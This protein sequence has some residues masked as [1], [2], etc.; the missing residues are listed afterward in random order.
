M[1]AT[2]TYPTNA[3]VSA[4]DRRIQLWTS[5]RQRAQELKQLHEPDWLRYWDWYRNVQQ[6]LTDDADW[7]RSNESVP[8]VFKI[9]ETLLP[10]YILGMFDS[11][12]WFS[13]EAKNQ[14]S[15]LYEN[16]CENLIKQAVEEM[17]IFPKLVEA[18]RYTA[19]MGHCWGKVIWREDYETLQKIVPKELTNRE[20][21]DAR[22]G[23]DAVQA[24]SE[25]YGEEMLE[26]PSGEQGV[27]LEL[28][29]EKTF[30]G[31][32]F[33]WKTLDRIFPDP[34][35]RERWYIEEIHTTLEELEEVQDDVGVYNE[36]AIQA[37]REDQTNRQPQGQYGG[38]DHIG[39][40]R[41]GTSAGVSIEYAREPETTEGIP[42]WIVTPQREGIGVTLWQCWGW[43]PPDDRGPD[44][45]EWRITVIGEGKHILR[46]EPSP[47]PD[48]KPPYFPIRFLT[49][50]GILYGDSIL[51]YVG[52]LAEQ[53]TRL[54][55]MR[56]DEV[57]LGVW[58]QYLF[59]KSSVVSDNTMLMQPGG[60]IEV[61]PAP[62][63]KI[64]DTFM[65][66][67]RRDMLGQV[68]QEDDWR[69]TQA[70]D[71]AAAGDIQQGAGSSGRTTATEVERK[72]Q[73]GNAR[74]VMQLMYN[75]YT[76]KKEILERVWKWLRMRLTTPR[77]VRLQGKQYANVDLHSLD[78]PVDIIVGGGL[79]A[80]SKQTR[81]QMDQELIQLLQSD[82]TSPYFKHIPI[83][84]RW[85]QDR[86]WKNP[87]SFLKT[88][89]ELKREQY[90]QGYNQA[91]AAINQAQHQQSSAALAAMGGAG[92][93]VP[94][95]SNGQ[96]GPPS[97]EGGGGAPPPG[98]VPQVSS[99]G[100]A[101][102]MVGGPIDQSGPPSG[103]PT[104]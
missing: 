27:D 7:W 35:G 80:L 16:L 42:E 5:R 19:I 52:P 79:F 63:Q 99:A 13:V 23:P 81:V 95:S 75:E 11:P 72:L 38:L 50:P 20:T 65:V 102:S 85:M 48:A 82:I 76:I 34:T 86:G 14:A 22:L 49:I 73:Q 77:L 66:L 2:A 15:E 28:K 29:K 30:D 97:A 9:V 61:N 103:S 33:E 84:K 43:V 25:L 94:P 46:D 87:D 26:L 21:L 31:P 58:Q 71:A 3:G 83:L 17:E 74:H 90:E 92:G 41:S 18:I 69:Q 32:E 93:D 47:T 100:R 104:G 36:A 68:W 24:A 4:G 51:K 1:G 56:L 40:A 67:P 59:R 54:S 37:L 55:N 101:A 91:M 88:E 45:A 10:R 8:T 44:G 6:P 57:F 70:E 53:Q 60:A 78:T 98:N 64:Q 39:D 62:G 89:E 12:D 96:S